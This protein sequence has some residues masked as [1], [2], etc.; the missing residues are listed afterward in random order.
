MNALSAL[1]ACLG[2]TLAAQAPPAGGDMPAI[3][4][5]ASSSSIELG[6][7]VSLT[8]TTNPPQGQ[9]LTLD[10]EASTTDYFSIAKI[11][12]LRVDIIPLAVGRLEIPL[13]WSLQTPSGVKKIASAPVILNVAEPPIAGGEIA[14]IKAPRAARRSLW[15]WLLALA[16]AA[17]GYWAYTRRRPGLRRAATPAPISDDRPA[18]V[19][20][21]AELSELEASGLW[22]AG[23]F[24]DFYI[25]LTE[26]L[27]QYLERRY[28]IPATHLTSSELHRHIRHAEIDRPVALLLKDLFDRADLVKFAKISPAQNWGGSDLAAAR[29]LVRQTTP[30]AAAVEASA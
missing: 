14:D 15:P 17:A 19:L 3:E 28:G 23:R 4:V 8:A 25:R 26:I 2:S 30:V 1:L 11:E 24:K 29:S 22:D 21:H 18:E 13:F 12:G 7:R 6:R 16:L 27:R 10:F 5:R 9:P 20:A